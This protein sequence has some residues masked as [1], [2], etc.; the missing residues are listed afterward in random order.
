MLRLVVLALMACCFTV[1]SAV[2]Q[3]Q[4]EQQ[5]PASEGTEQAADENLLRLNFGVS[6]GYGVDA[7]NSDVA[8]PYGVVVRPRVGLTLPEGIYLG[9]IVS[10]GLGGEGKTIVKDPTMMM[11]DATA[12]LSSLYIGAEFGGDIEVGKHGLVRP[13]YGMGLMKI[14]SEAC[15][16]GVCED[17]TKSFPSLEFGLQLLLRFGAIYGGVDL[18]YLMVPN[19][20]TINPADQAF[21]GITI[22]AMPG[23]SI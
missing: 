4:Q 20:Y 10:Y 12:T 16:S 17:R 9:G 21:V 14:S 22:G 8:S 2:A 1:S 13:T 15:G 19:K 5:D 3:D 11:F 23:F 6:V 7:F 18:G